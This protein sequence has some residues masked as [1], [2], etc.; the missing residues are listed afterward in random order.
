MIIHTDASVRDREV[1]FGF[2]IRT[3]DTT[4]ES[5]TFV[6]GEYTSV[7][8]EYLSIQRA[9]EFASQ[10][11]DERYVYIYTDCKEV[12]KNIQN[13]YRWTSRTR[14]LEQLLPQGFSI[15]YIPREWNTEAHQLV[16]T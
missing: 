2:I 10:L 7:S 16:S 9:A 11:D 13:N 4:Y 5:S 6:A 12:A 1:C 8:G 15:N 14:R 3:E